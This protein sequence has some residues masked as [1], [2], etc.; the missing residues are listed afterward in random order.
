LLR[1]HSRFRRKTRADNLNRH[2]IPPT[3]I[4]AE[5]VRA[6]ETAKLPSALRRT[7][8]P[9]R[10]IVG[11]AAVAQRVRAQTSGLQTRIDPSQR[12]LSQGKTAAARGGASIGGLADRHPGE[13]RQLTVSFCTAGIVRLAVGKISFLL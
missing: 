12:H 9:S 8:K 7:R 4:P 2:G 13:A 5:Q 6:T 11:A 1:R 3:R 10:R